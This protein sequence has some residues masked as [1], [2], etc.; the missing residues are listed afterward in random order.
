MS[1]GPP[2]DAGLWLILSDAS[3]VFTME[4]GRR[5]YVK[6]FDT[7]KGGVI[8]LEMLLVGIYRDGTYECAHQSAINC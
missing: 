6:H 7:R 4:N 8:S 2:G 5:F 1:P 3:P